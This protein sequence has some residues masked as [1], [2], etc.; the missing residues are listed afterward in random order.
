PGSHSAWLRGPDAPAIPY[1]PLSLRRMPGAVEAGRASV[2]G[3][4]IAG[5]CLLKGCSSPT[6]GRFRGC[7]PARP[8]PPEEGG[9]PV[10]HRFPATPRADRPARRRPPSSVPA[11]RRPYGPRPCSAVR[12]L[13]KRGQD[14]VAEG[15]QA[16][17]RHDRIGHLHDGRAVFRGDLN[18]QPDALFVDGNL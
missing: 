12:A 4:W 10:P 1:E 5:G 8:D 3:R 17:L 11:A 14:P 7:R 6:Q 15:L 16:I 9:D 13:L 18:A 2:A